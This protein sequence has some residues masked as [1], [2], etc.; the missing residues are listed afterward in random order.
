MVNVASDKLYSL[1][2]YG[3]PLKRSKAVICDFSCYSEPSWKAYMSET[4]YIV[5]KT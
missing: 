1:K 5:I 3:P 2:M 4:R